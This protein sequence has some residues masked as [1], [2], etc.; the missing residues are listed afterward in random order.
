MD[1]FGSK[2]YELIVLVPKFSV[3]IQSRKENILRAW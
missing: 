2:N 1:G 3:K